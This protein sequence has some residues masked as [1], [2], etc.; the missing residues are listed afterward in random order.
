LPIALM[1]VSALKLPLSSLLA[2]STAFLG[3][4]PN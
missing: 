2:V 4:R 3:L 1:A